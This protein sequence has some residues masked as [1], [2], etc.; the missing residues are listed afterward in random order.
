MYGLTWKKKDIIRTLLLLLIVTL[1]SFFVSNAADTYKERNDLPM[2]KN[3]YSC[4]TCDIN[5]ISE[6]NKLM[7]NPQGVVYQYSAYFAKIF[8]NMN[9]NWYLFFFSFFVY[10]TILYIISKISPLHYVSIFF[11]LTDFRFWE[12]GYNILRAGL[13][14]TIFLIVFFIL[15]KKKNILKKT[16]FFITGLPFLAHSSALVFLL[17]R[18]KKYNIFFLLFILSISIA[19]YQFFDD[20]IKNILPQILP[21]KMNNKINFY[22]KYQENY[23]TN[24]ASFSIPIH[25]FMILTFAFFLIYI[26]KYSYKFFVY[27]FNIVLILFVFSYIFS[28]LGI[29]YRFIGFMPPFIA[30]LFTYEIQILFKKIKS[31]IL[32][33]IVLILSFSFILVIFFKNYELIIKAF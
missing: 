11:L 17:I 27:S 5:S 19:L 22:Y 4:L 29:G 3:N 7:G 1:S 8:F 2:Y 21:I 30:I 26:K 33:M 31:N 13:A 15:Y 9:F 24:L 20:I 6:C 14:E 12:Y 16:K 18:Q 25:Y 10:F 28:L 32:K 23:S